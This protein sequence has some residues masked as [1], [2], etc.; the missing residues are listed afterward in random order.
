MALTDTTIRN[1]KPGI[2]AD[3]KPT[4]KPYKLGAV[5]RLQP[6]HPQSL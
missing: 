1:A 5:R 3:G 2:N 4:N 6:L